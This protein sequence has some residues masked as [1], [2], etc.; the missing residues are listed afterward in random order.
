M[1]IANKKMAMPDKIT[2]IN[3]VWSAMIAVMLTATVTLYQDRS[4]VDGSNYPQVTGRYS[5]ISYY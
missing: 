4:D 5:D 3:L 1:M 2:M